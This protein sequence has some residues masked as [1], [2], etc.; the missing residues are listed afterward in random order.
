M[1]EWNYPILI[2]LT[3][4]ELCQVVLFVP[5]SRVSTVLDETPIS[6]EKQFLL[7]SAQIIIVQSHTCPILIKFWQH[8]KLPSHYITYC[9]YYTLLNRICQPIFR[10]FRGRRFGTLNIKSDALK[11]DIILTL[12]ILCGFCTSNRTLGIRIPPFFMFS[13]RF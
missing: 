9:L 5:A 7:K 6:V 10:I 2:N 4:S 11:M 13:I 3:F 8:H 12:P 1:S